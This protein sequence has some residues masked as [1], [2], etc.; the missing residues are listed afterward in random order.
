MACCCWP[1]PC[2]PTRAPKP[3]AAAAAAAAAVA[4]A[5]MFPEAWPLGLWCCAAPGECGGSG[6]A[7]GLLHLRKWL[8]EL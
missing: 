3:L 8:G 7:P 2:Q 5:G 6:G 1:T 4:A